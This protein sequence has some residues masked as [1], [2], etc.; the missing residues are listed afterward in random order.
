[1]NYYEQLNKIID[2]IEENLTEKIDYK[3]LAKIIGTSS[4]T[5]QRIFVFLTGITLT[6]YIRKRR[7]SR[8]AEELLSTNIKIID[9]ALKYQYDSPISFSNAFKKMHGI[10]PQNLR[11]KQLALKSFPKIKFNP[12][13]EKMEE[14]EYKIINFENQ[15]FYGITTGVIKRNNSSAIKNLF[16][17][18]RKN[19]ILDFIIDNSD[20]KELYY[21]LS[22]DIYNDEEITDK[23]QYYILGKNFNKGFVTIEIPKA[24]YACFKLNNKRQSDILKLYNTIYTKWLPSSKYTEII[25]FPQLEV[26]YE[27]YC[28]ICIPVK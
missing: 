17:K 21:G 16:D 5:L 12:T 6:D 28:E 14:L 22:V 7:L 20:G 24:T 18:S 15:K 25:N 3:E 11:K 8:A 27:N 1:M 10:S 19:K 9:L 23:I 4:Y 2:K 26:Y 13:I